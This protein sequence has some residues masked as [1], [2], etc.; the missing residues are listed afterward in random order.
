MRNDV[1]LNFPIPIELHGEFEELYVIEKR[2]RKNKLLKKD[3]IVEVIKMGIR[4]PKWFK[5]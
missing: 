1:K 5:K 4:S 2:K 3:F